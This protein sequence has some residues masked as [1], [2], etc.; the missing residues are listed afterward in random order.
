[1][2]SINIQT[3]QAVMEILRDKMKIRRLTLKLTQEGLSNRSGVSLGS[4][5]R[6]E[7][8]A[9]ISLH[10]L[11]KIALVLECLDDFTTIADT[12]QDEVNS[13]DELLNSK[14]LKVSKR[15]SIK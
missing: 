14:P 5:K 10:S 4:V 9:E 7:K 1:M 13:I 12:K 8:S 3:P 11:M 6:F 2:L 15:G